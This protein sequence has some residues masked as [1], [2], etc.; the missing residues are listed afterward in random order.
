VARII[1]IE[2]LFNKVKTLEVKI[3]ELKNLAKELVNSYR[4]LII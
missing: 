1:N 2:Q 4:N 3:E